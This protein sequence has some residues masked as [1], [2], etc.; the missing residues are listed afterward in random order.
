MRESLAGGK[1]LECT[2]ICIDATPGE[3]REGSEGWVG[4]MRHALWDLRGVGVEEVKVM[5]AKYEY[6][7]TTSFGIYCKLVDM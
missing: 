6:S 5:M 2:Y 7:V 1:R 4:V 3:R